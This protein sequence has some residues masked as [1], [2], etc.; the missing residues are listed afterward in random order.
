MIKFDSVFPVETSLD[1]A[2]TAG[3]SWYIEPLY[4]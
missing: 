1:N 2:V 4:Y 3:A